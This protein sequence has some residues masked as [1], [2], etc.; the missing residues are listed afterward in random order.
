MLDALE[1]PELRELYK[2]R[3]SHA[4]SQT[5]RDRLTDLATRAAE[6]LGWNL[7]VATTVSQM[8]HTRNWMIHWGTRGSFAIEDTDGIVRLVRCLELIVHVNLLLDVGM[9]EDAIRAGVAS[10]WRF[11]ERP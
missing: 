3:L 4:N 8:I 7:D 5:Q 9:D 11:Q 2:E 1:D 10:G 6:L